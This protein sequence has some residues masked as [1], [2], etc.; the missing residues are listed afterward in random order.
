MDEI[1][2][3]AVIAMVVYHLFY[4]MGYVYHI[5]AGAAAFLFLR[6]FSPIVPIVFITISGISSQLSRS[7]IR[8]GAKLL[9]IAAAVTLV[10]VLITPQ[11]AIY[12]GILHFLSIAVLLYGFIKRWL[13]QIP[14]KLG[15]VIFLVLYLITY[16]IPSGVLGIPGILSVSLPTQLY[17]TNFLFPLGFPGPGFTSADYFPI[18]PNL[19][20]FLF[21]TYLGKYALLGKFPAFLYKKRVPFLAFTGRH[22]L[23]IYILHQPVIFGILWLITSFTA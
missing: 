2:G 14:L 23:W 9:P 5:Q 22:A 18:F 21:G 11:S 20:L 17:S 15:L 4:T 6:P 1:R 13:D 12:F 3:L 19:F 16:G 10:T 8:R 7:N